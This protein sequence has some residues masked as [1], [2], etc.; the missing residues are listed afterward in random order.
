LDKSILRL[1]KT[2]SL[3]V[4]NG[5]FTANQHLTKHRQKL[6]HNNALNCVLFSL[7]NTE[8]DYRTKLPWN[9]DFFAT[10]NLVKTPPY[11]RRDKW[12]KT[13]KLHQQLSTVL[14]LVFFWQERHWRHISWHS[15]HTKTTAST[16]VVVT[17]FSF[18]FYFLPI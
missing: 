16:K 8:I 1:S 7:L 4:S 9:A 13:W 11:N 6:R 5:S 12:Q 15:I 18:F 3:V 10:E 17:Y 2:C 14:S